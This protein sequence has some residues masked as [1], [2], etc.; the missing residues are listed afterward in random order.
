MVA[1]RST[2]RLYFSKALIRQPTR[3]DYGYNVLK[4]LRNPVGGFLIEA[5]GEIAKF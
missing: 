4:L 2:V 3:M 5:F 1:F